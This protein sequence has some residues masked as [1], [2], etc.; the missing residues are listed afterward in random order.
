VGIKGN[1]TK[2]AKTQ[3]ALPKWRGRRRPK[4]ERESR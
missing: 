3:E 4:N 1:L 2:S